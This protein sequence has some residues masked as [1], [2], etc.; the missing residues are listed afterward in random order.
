MPIV[1]AKLFRGE[2]TRVI[3]TRKAAENIV[4][5]WAEHS[6][7]GK[8]EDLVDVIDKTLHDILIALCDA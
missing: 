6:P 4:L 8:P 3:D 1:E 2:P 7:D 5:Y